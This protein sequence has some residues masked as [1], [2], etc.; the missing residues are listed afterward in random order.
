[1]LKEKEYE[2][3]K[4]YIENSIKKY[5]S[6]YVVKC[7]EWKIHT[8][9]TEDEFIYDVYFEDYKL[10]IYIGSIGITINYMK[11]TAKTSW[12]TTER[13]Y[14]NNDGLDSIIN[15]MDSIFDIDIDFFRLCKRNYSINKL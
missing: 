8:N 3:Y 7:D 4:V 13:K 14:H 12:E 10:Y 15:A 9:P 6:N 2:L 11:R 5:T 1:M